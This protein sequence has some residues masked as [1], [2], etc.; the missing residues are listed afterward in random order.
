MHCE[1]T[2]YYKWTN[3]TVDFAQNNMHQFMVIF[4]LQKAFQFQDN[5]VWG[6]GSRVQLQG[7]VWLN[8]EYCGAWKAVN[9]NVSCIYVEKYWTRWGSKHF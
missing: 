2:G 3:V 4:A 1:Y 8:Y 7:T 5:C 6:P 9:E